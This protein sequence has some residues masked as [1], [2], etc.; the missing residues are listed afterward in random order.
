MLG[1]AAEGTSAVDDLKLRRAGAD[2]AED[3]G[4]HLDAGEF[5]EGGGFAADDFERVDADALEVG[6]SAEAAGSVGQSVLRTGAAIAV[7]VP[8]PLAIVGEILA[9]PAVAARGKELAVP[10]EVSLHVREIGAEGADRVVV[11]G[12]AEAFF[13]RAAIVQE[14]DFDFEVAGNIGADLVDLVEGDAA[15]KDDAA[16]AE[17]FMKEAD[18]FGVEGR[19]DGADVEFGV[20][21][22]ARELKEEIDV[23]N[24]QGIDADFFRE[25]AREIENEGEL[26]SGVVRR[27]EGNEERERSGVGGFGETRE[28]GVGREAAAFGGAAIEPNGALV[29]SGPIFGDDAAVELLGAGGLEHFEFIEFADGSEEF[30]TS[31]GIRGAMERRSTSPRAAR[32]RRVSSAAGAWR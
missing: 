25:L 2:A 32:W 28:L 13:E 1:L 19:G 23:G 11:R 27:V 24:D 4:G 3:I 17:L 6:E 22:E 30:H 31:M 10:L 21:T 7:Q 9:E 15:G 29:L 12:G 5:L 20:E 18:G 16:D 26:F 14:E 8:D